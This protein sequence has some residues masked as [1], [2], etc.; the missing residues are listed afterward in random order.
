MSQRPQSGAEEAANSLSHSLACLL[1]AASLPVLLRSSLERAGELRHAVAVS[2]FAAT[3]VLLY[4][5]SAVFHGLPAG[6]AKHWFGRLD[7][8]AIYLFIAGSY[9]PFAAAMLQGDRA[10]LMLGL[11]WLLALIGA[12]VALLDL[13]RHPIA[14][15]ALYVGLGWLVLVAALPA[16]KQVSAAG[17]TLLLAGGVVYTLGAAVYLLSARLRFAHFVWHLAV[18][19]GSML[20]FLAALRHS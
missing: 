15:T 19:G 16:L 11:V 4:L 20:H 6:R 14:S 5:A 3:M 13:L 1:A 8:A 18:M 17:V 2:V 7:H 10:W 12:L 9:T